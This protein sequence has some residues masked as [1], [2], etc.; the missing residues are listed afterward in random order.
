MSSFST[1]RR[2]T[3]STRARAPA[4][5]GPSFPSRRCNS[6]VR[7]ASNRCRSATMVGTALRERCHAMNFVTSSLT[8][9][10]RAPPPRRV[11]QVLLDD[12]LQVVDVVEEH[13]LDFADSRIDVARHGDVDDESGAVRRWPWRLQMRSRDDR[14]AATGGRNN[15]VGGPERVA[16]P[17]HGTAVPATSPRAP[18]RARACGS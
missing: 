7:M 8:I 14:A 2:V 3:S 15:D 13:L 6:D 11:R 16:M 10:S 1:M 12:A 5:S 9:D 4:V 17:S 18:P